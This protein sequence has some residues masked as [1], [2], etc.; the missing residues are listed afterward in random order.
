[1]SET[2]PNRSDP[3][4]DAEAVDPAEN[5]ALNEAWAALGQLLNAAQTPLN[6]AAFVDAV[7]MRLSQRRRQVRWKVLALAA[8]VLAVV[9]ATWM[10]VSGWIGV[11]G[12]RAPVAVLPPGKGSPLAKALPRGNARPTQELVHETDA[13][14]TELTIDPLPSAGWNDDWDDELALAQEQVLATRESWRRP[15][16]RLAAVRERMDELEAEFGGGAL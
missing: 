9:G 16:D 7:C 5:A 4:S 12:N 14:Q 8:S 3:Q 2:N 10:G 6:E 15:A 11:N 1:M 13:T